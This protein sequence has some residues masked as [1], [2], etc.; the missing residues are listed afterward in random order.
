MTCEDGILKLR[1]DG[2]KK[3]TAAKSRRAITMHA[4]LRRISPYVQAA[5]HPI[6]NILS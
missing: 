2:A 1:Q 3:H 5:V 4:I 6:V